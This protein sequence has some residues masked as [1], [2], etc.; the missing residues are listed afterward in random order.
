M[1]K[2]QRGKKYGKKKGDINGF[3]F[4]HGKYYWVGTLHD[5]CR[6]ISVTL[7]FILIMLRDYLV[8]CIS[9]KSFFVA[10]YFST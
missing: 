6:L 3:C 10:W 7:P 9:P 2:K 8:C 4:M 1:K 5:L